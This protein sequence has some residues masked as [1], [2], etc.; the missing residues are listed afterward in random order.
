M[1][2]L[3]FRR[4]GYGVRLLSLVNLDGALLHRSDPGLTQ[5]PAHRGARDLD[6]FFSLSFS[7]KCVS[8]SP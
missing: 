6:L 2:E 4:Q 3:R 8:L 5:H 1:S 7:A